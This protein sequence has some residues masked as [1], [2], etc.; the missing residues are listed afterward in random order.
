[1]ARH[2]LISA[3]AGDAEAG[4]VVSGGLDNL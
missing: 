4:V 3:I 2:D 1:M